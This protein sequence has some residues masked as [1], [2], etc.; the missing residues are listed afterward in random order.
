M[1]MELRMTTSA[2]MEKCHGQRKMTIDAKWTIEEQLEKAK[3]G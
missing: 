2:D 3:K 1:K